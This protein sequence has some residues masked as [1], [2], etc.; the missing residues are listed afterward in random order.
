MGDEKL[1]Q[2][3]QVMKHILQNTPDE[4]ILNMGKANSTKICILLKIY[5][6]LA[7]LL[8]FL[9]PRLVGSVSLRMLDL[10]L[11]FGLTSMCPLAFAFYGGTL[12][13][14]GH[15]YTTEACRLGRWGV[16]GQ[17]LCYFSKYRF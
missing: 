13:S 6:E 3:M 12:L 1:K 2:E 14:M 11:N 4:I 10:T 7:S 15:E 16:F 5:A 9:K 8:Q 17:V